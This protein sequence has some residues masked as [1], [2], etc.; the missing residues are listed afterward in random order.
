MRETGPLETDWI[1]DL[2]F[3]KSQGEGRRNLWGGHLKNICLLG[4]QR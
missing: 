2:S 4:G 1:R 3:I